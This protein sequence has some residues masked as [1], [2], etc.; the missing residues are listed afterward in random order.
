MCVGVCG[1]VLQ[2]WVA[3]ASTQPSHAFSPPPVSHTPSCSR[4]KAWTHPQDPGGL[5]T[6]ARLYVTV[7]VVVVK[8]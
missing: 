4:E 5:Y 3:H 7:V 6:A 8:W 1:A 2:N